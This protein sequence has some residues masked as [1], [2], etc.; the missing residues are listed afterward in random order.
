[1]EEYPR[2]VR[3]HIL[4]LAVL[5]DSFIWSGM[6]FET[7]WGHILQA[8]NLNGIKVARE[9]KVEVK[10]TRWNSKWQYEFRARVS[11]QFPHDC[12][13]LR[14]FHVKPI[15]APIKSYDARYIVSAVKAV[16]SSPKC[17]IGTGLKWKHI[18]QYPGNLCA[19][20]VQAHL[21]NLSVP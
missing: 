2:C 12:L 11:A 19:A 7:H 18:Q 3:M 4:V 14:G 8:W 1:M 15:L 13:G 21:S 17:C 16:R 9:R 6:Q 5:R 10:Q 20:P